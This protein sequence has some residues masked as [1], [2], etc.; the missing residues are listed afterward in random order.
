MKNESLKNFVM[1]SYQNT[2]ITQIQQLTSNLANQQHLMQFNNL[3]V[4]ASLPRIPL[5][6][7]MPKFTTNI[8]KLSLPPSICYK[9]HNIKALHTNYRII[10]LSESIEPLSMYQTFDNFIN[11]TQQKNTKNN[12]TSTNNKREKV[13]QNYFETEQPSS[14]TSSNTSTSAIIENINQLLRNICF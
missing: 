14:G 6:N 8:N 3:L 5:P 7:M 12:K 13:Q 2:I 1:M 11:H 9:K 10:A 4:E